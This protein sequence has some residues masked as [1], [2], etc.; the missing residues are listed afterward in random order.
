MAQAIVCVLVLVKAFRQDSS[1]GIRKAKA[2][3]PASNLSCPRNGKRTASLRN[4][5]AACMLV[6]L[7]LEVTATRG[8]DREGVMGRLRQP[9]YRPT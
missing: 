1:T 2:P 3:R 4:S 9:G 5:S 8:A 7:P 6:T